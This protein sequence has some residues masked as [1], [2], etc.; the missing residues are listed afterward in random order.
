MPEN[1]NTDNNEKVNNERL[2]YLRRRRRLECVW[3]VLL[4][5]SLF[6]LL[7]YQGWLYWGQNQ[8]LPWLNINL[9][10]ENW[11]GQDYADVLPAVQQNEGLWGS[12]T[13]E[14]P[15]YTEL[16]RALVLLNGNE[17][18]RFSSNITVNIPVYFPVLVIIDHYTFLLY[19]ENH[20]F[21]N[22]P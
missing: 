10:T 1:K 19:G 2:L 21:I 3:A 22:S 12:V 9:A 4:L 7:F 8:K 16:H 5:S 17:V 14:L 20:I 15:D 6:L 13:L 18:G 11:Y